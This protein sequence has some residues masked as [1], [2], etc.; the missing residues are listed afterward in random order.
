[1]GHLRETRT[2]GRVCSHFE[3]H[4]VLTK[5]AVSCLK[6]TAAVRY[7]PPWDESDRYHRTDILRST[8]V[9]GK[10]LNLGPDREADFHCY[11]ELMVKPATAPVPAQAS[12]AVATL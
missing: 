10:Q 7:K 5:T 4:A 2:I 9:A 8:Q 3:R 6:F 12:G 11:H 1:M